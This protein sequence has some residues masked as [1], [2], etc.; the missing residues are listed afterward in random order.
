M[1]RRTTVKPA[2]NSTLLWIA[3]L[4]TFLLWPMHATHAED[5]HAED[6]SANEGSESAPPSELML[7]TERVVVFKDGYSLFVRRGTATADASGTVH[8][9]DVPDAA[10][11]GTFWA[12]SGDAKLL[13]MKAEVVTT[14]ST[15]TETTRAI[16]I[17]DLLRA[18][19]GKYVALHRG[20][21]N[22]VWGKINEVL[23]RGLRKVPERIRRLQPTP[24]ESPAVS[25]REVALEGGAYVRVRTQPEGRNVVLPVNSIHSISAESLVTESR[26][27]FETKVSRKR[28]SVS[29]GDDVAGKDVTVRLLY[30]APGLRWIPSYRVSGELKD[31]AN[32]ALQ[33][34]VLNEAMDLDGVALDLVV[35]VPHFKFRNVVSPLSL[36][37][38]LRNSLNRAAPQLMGQMASNMSHTH[39]RTRAGEV[40]APRSTNTMEIA[41]E[42]GAAG[43]ND[44]FVYSIPSLSLTRGGRAT[45]PLW[46]QDVPLRH[47][48]TLD[49]TLGRDARGGK[50][51]VR[52]GQVTGRGR[53][54]G[55]TP[56]ASA[57]HVVWHQLELSN[58]S[59][60]PWT[61]GPALTMR[62]LL[63]L[64][65]D[66]LS[67]TSV[68]EKSLL[69][70]T[71][72]IDVRA[73]YSEEETNRTA[74]ALEWSG[75]RYALVSKKATVKIRNFRGTRST[76]RIR[77]GLGGK[78]TSI[79]ND[80][81]YVV[82]DFR[83]GDWTN[84][85]YAGRVNNHS[86]VEWAVDLDAGATQELTFEYQ[87]YVR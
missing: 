34:E 32:L 46:Q 23:E 62:G 52:G 75:N 78:V 24:P 71:V 33:A 63:P 15:T 13:G 51:F 50:T 11:L 20:A 54:A 37:S 30:F 69:P 55:D 3:L 47:L 79:S 21:G 41:P 14:K 59:E 6:K 72:A 57:N 19:Q 16:S 12:F 1:K 58:K 38:H 77:I 70:L 29:L 18:N 4:G 49:I 53:T 2:R 85:G 36:E 39:F 64:G 22:D 31:A 84:G 10:V 82:N 80:G 74:N 81:T 48:Y 45:L 8:T 5:K 68:G 25:E 9:Y 28:L 17:L 73:D 40:H 76:T 83:A 87:Y 7:T 27:T 44:L 56:L 61:T 60:V 67:Y 42:L 43:S 66:M 86:D 35:G 26:R 65:Q